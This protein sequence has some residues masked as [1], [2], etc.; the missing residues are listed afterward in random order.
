[1]GVST[2]QR[3]FMVNLFWGYDGRGFFAWSLSCLNFNQRAILGIWFFM[4]LGGPQ[5]TNFDLIGIVI[6]LI[7]ATD[8][9]V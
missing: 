2:Q 5:L 1:M 6:H 7:F 9:G 4:E 8:I 3:S